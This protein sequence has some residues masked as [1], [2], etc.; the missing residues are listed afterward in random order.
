MIIFFIFTYFSLGR[1]CSFQYGHWTPKSGEYFG[2]VINELGISREDVERLNPQEN[3]DN[4]FPNKLYTVPYEKPKYSAAWLTGCPPTL[5]LSA[6]TTPAASSPAAVKSEAIVTS[7]TLIYGVSQRPSRGSSAHQAKTGSLPTTAQSTAGPS[8]SESTGSTSTPPKSTDTSDKPQ[9]STEMATSTSSDMPAVSSKVATTTSR[10]TQESTGSSSTLTTEIRS[11]GGT[12]T[13][14]K[15]KVPSSSSSSTTSRPSMALSVTLATSTGEGRTTQ[16]SKI[17]TT[18]G[19]ASST[20]VTTASSQ[21]AGTSPNSLPTTLTT[22]TKRASTLPSTSK[23][24]TTATTD[25][26]K[27]IHPR[28]CFNEADTENAKGTSEEGVSETAKEWCNDHSALSM[29]KGDNR[30]IGIG[31]HN[32]VLYE[33]SVVWQFNCDG[34]DQDV[35]SPLGSTKDSCYAIMTE[36]WKQCLGGSGAFIRY[37]C[38]LYQLRA[39]VGKAQGY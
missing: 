31:R 11:N 20:T 10:R 29:G 22:K 24:A 32:K 1:A 28:A 21:G 6:T 9:G 38:L 15:S 5:Q 17:G 18:G 7:S 36:N 4:I 26:N 25:P 19:G 33:Y 2:L 37:G 34:P 3:I 8:S 35:F 13:E 39:G 23:A 12:E 30:L 16:P 14:E 27:Q